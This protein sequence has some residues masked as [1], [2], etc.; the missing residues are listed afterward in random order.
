VRRLGGVGPQ[1]GRARAPRVGGYRVTRRRW[2]AARGCGKR[3]HELAEFSAYDH[4]AFPCLA[5]MSANQQHRGRLTSK[6]L[7][8]VK[9]AQISNRVS[10]RAMI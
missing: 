7:R 10:A 9:E 8:V 6:K 1:A 4:S 2:P 3:V 5:P